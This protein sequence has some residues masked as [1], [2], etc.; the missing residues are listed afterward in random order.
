MIR[1]EDAD[2]SRN[3]ASSNVDERRAAYEPPEVEALGSVVEIT[4]GGSG[5]DADVEEAGSG[6]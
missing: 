1:R 6:V 4:R 5:G 2:D 3:A